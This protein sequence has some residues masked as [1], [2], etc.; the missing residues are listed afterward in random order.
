MQLPDYLRQ[1]SYRVPQEPSTGP[2]ANAYG[3]RDFWDLL[4]EEPER[5][6][7]FNSY[8]TIHKEGRAN[9]LDTYSVENLAGQDLQA[10]KDAVL[11][12]DIGGNRGHDLKAFNARRGGMQGRLILQDQPWVVS[13]IDPQWEEEGIEPMAHDFFTPQPVKGKLVKGEF[14]GYL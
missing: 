14:A 10:D 2:F 5:A 3:G 9:W 8:M 6:K 1:T 7:M 4:R 13:D 12:V 11:L